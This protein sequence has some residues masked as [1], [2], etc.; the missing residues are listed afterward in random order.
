MWHFYW[1]YFWL[2]PWIFFHGYFFHYVISRYFSETTISLD[3]FSADSFSWDLFPLAFFLG[4]FY[5]LPNFLVNWTWC[6]HN[7]LVTISSSRS[8]LK[9]KKRLY[10]VE[11][12][13]SAFS[14]CKPIWFSQ[15]CCTCKTVMWFSWSCWIVALK[16]VSSLSR[17]LKLLS[18]VA[19]N[20]GTASRKYS[21]RSISCGA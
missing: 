13:K 4:Y 3:I 21:N 18:A 16:Y 19:F 7:L 20:A 9:E 2:H 5:C 12:T 14:F 17:S 15:Y 6:G 11:D 10:S 8:T 1:E